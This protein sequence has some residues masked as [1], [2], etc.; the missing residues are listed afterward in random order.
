MRVARSGR[1]ARDAV[2]LMRLIP[3][4]EA[5][6]RYGVVFLLALVAVVFFIVAPDG[7]ASRV[8]GLSAHAG[9][10]ADA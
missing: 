9:D 1:R 2:R 8:L 4:P 6:Y 3:G 7:A 5:S 10:A